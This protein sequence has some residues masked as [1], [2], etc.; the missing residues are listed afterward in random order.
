MRSFDMPSYKEL[1]TSFY[2]LRNKELVAQ[3]YN[4]STMLIKKWCKKYGI[5]AQ[6]KK[7]YIER[8]EIEFLGKEPKKHNENYGIKIAQ[9]DPETKEVIQIFENKTKALKYFNSNSS[10]N[11]TRA[12]NTGGKAFGYYWKYIQD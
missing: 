1:F 12:C 2:E 11:I 10:L 5:N 4:V 9:L 8:Y 6:N 7:A 3:K